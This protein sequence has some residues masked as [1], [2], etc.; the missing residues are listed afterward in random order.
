MSSEIHSKLKISTQ[1]KMIDEPDSLKHLGN[2]R[3]DL[4]RDGFLTIRILLGQ[5]LLSLKVNCDVGD[6]LLGKN[7]I[8]FIANSCRHVLS[9]LKRRALSNCF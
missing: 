4:L 8:E 6:L 3:P 9:N 1:V 5:H 2:D 7:D